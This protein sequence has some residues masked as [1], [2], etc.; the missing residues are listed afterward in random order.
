MLLVCPHGEGAEHP[1]RLVPEQAGG[2]EGKGRMVETVTELVVNLVRPHTEVIV[3]NIQLPTS[4]Q[5]QSKSI[6]FS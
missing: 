2:Q 1:D 3:L 6:S 5:R 4:S